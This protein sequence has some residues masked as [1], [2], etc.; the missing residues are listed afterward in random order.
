M[1]KRPLV[2]LAAAYLCG[3]CGAAK[4]S[5]WC[6]LLLL[7]F[8]IV[9]AIA[10]IYLQKDDHFNRHDAFLLLVPVFLFAGA[11]RFQIQ[12]A[13]CLPEQNELEHNQLATVQ[14][15]VKK[16]VSTGGRIQVTLQNAVN[17]KGDKFCG[18][19]LILCSSGVFCE[20]EVS[21]LLGSRIEVTGTY[22]KFMP[23]TNPGQFAEAE[24]QR[25]LGYCMKMQ[26]KK[27]R[28]I[29]PGTNP[30][31]KFL[32]KRKQ[33]VSILYQKLFPEK[34]AGILAAML[35]G[36]R[37]MLGKEVKELY[38]QGGISHILSISGMHL[39]LLGLGM[40]RLLKR[41]RC[42]LLGSVAVSIGILF[43]YGCLTGFSISTRR[44]F[45]MLFLSMAAKLPGYTADLPSSLS[46]AALWILWERPMLLFQASFLLSFGAVA[47]V[48]AAMKLQSVGTGVSQSDSHIL[49]IR[50]TL[51]ISG[52]IQLMTLPVTLY[53][54]Y[55]LPVY[56]VFL[57]LIVLP[58]LS[59][60]AGTAVVAGLAGSFCLSLGAFF[61]GSSFGILKLYELLC[62]VV[63]TLPMSVWTLGKMS[64]SATAV[65]YLLLFGIIWLCQRAGNRKP[66]LLFVLL[67]LPVVL[68]PKEGM[69]VVFL[70]VGQGDCAFVEDKQGTTML[71][72]GGSSSVKN[73]GTYRILP[74]LNSRGIQSVDYVFLSHADADHT[75]GILELLQDNAVRCLI[76]PETEDVHE[77]FTDA[78]E[79]ADSTGC[80][81]RYLNAGESLNAGDW[82]LECLAPE[83]KTGFSAGE[84]AGSMVLRLTYQEVTFY[85]TG[86]IE[87]EGESAFIRRLS[88]ESQINQNN[89]I[90]K[91]AHHGSKYS[92]TERFLELVHPKTAIISCEKDNSYGHPHRELLERLET[93]SCKIYTTPDCGAV[94]IRTNGKQVKI[95]PF[96]E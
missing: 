52:I 17:T 87:K 28:I 74:F 92:T 34:E 25:A 67:L 42:G 35:L 65:Y 32:A 79:L 16:A 77:V 19:L 66:L 84:N 94:T 29:S 33:Q 18:D 82:N 53:F 37:E 44:A 26:A 75:N 5:G 56:A 93:R 9:A 61:A 89:L 73:V 10:F 36:E 51:R 46:F 43:A 23:A 63:Q 40:F 78:I 88:K 12:A 11:I 20:T 50:E 21:E 8:W 86:D 70:D 27:L 39:S 83:Q 48:I 38:K 69:S 3:I 41:C 91:V 2:V 68:R 30:F 6:W 72:D 57:N 7:F 80:Q 14:G 90:L 62:K 96:C 22:L 15:T 64:V 24:Y 55:E 4:D 95:I 13:P 47:G 71:I 76:L 31:Q 1:I 58:L 85:F 45:L 59:F 60:L 49:K 54:F 81:I